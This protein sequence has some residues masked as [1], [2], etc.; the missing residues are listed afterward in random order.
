MEEDGKAGKA[1]KGLKAVN[2]TSL[3]GGK[4]QSSKTLEP[5]L[6]LTP[7]CRAVC[8]RAEGGDSATHCPETCHRSCR[9]GVG[10]RLLSARSF[11]QHC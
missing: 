3:R 7:L 1:S 2:K 11:S 9:N 5:V 8:D 10:Q 6:F 4:G